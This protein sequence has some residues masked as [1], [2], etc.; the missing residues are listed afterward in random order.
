MTRRADAETA[1]G[2]RRIAPDAP[3]PPTFDPHAVVDADRTRLVLASD[4]DDEV[5]DAVRAVVDAARAGT[6]LDR[7]AVL[8]ASPEPYARLVHEHLAAAGITTN[9]AAVLPLAGRV[10]GRTLLDLLALP[11]RGFR[12]QDVFAWLASAPLLRD[13]R[14]APTPPG[15]GCRVRPASSPAA[16]TGTTAS[17]PSPTERDAVRGRR[18][19]RPGRTRVAARSSPRRK[20][21]AP[22]TSARSC[23]ASSTTSTAPP[24]APAAGA[25]TRA[26]A[27]GRLTELLGGPA[28]RDQ[29]PDSRA[30]GGRAGRAGARP[31][32]RARRGRGGGRARR[33]HPHARARARVRPRAGRPLRRGRARRLRHHGARPRPRPRR[34]ARPGRGLVPRAPSATTRSSPTTS[35][36]PPATSSRCAR[37]GSTASTASSSPRSPARPGTCSASPAATCAAAASASRRA[38]CSTSPAALAGTP[39]APD[40]LLG[41][42]DAVDRARAVVRRRPARLRLPRHR[43]GAPAPQPARRRARARRRPRRGRRPADRRR[44]RGHGR[45]PQRPLHPLRR[46]PR[47]ARH[48]VA[49][50]RAR[51]APRASRRGRAARSPTSSSTC[52]ASS[53]S[54]T[55]RSRCRSSPLDRGSLVHEALERFVLEV[56][57]RP[58]GRAAVAG[59]ALVARRPG[60]ARRDRRRAVRRLRGAGADGPADL[61]APRPGP[62]PRRPPTLP[63][64]RRPG[65]GQRAAP[66]RRRRARR[67]ACATPTL[68]AVP[69]DAARRARRPLPGQGRPGRRRRRRHAPRRRL[70]DR[71]TRNYEG[72]SADDPDPPAPHLQLAVYGAAARRHRATPDAD[73]HAEYWFVSTKGT[74]RAHRLPGHGR[75]PRPGVGASSAPSSTGIEAGVFPSHP[76][77]ASTVDLG[78]VRVVRPRRARHHRAAPRRGTRKRADPRSP[79][80]PTWP[81]RSRVSSPSKSRVRSLD[82]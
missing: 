78:R 39:V 79:A 9:G 27:R 52:S 62:D 24:A 16:P 13:G 38:G 53:G 2:V 5:R 57:D 4:A 8:Y 51:P 12:R 46:Q 58:A 35:A 3:A 32:R 49:G 50:R 42:S 23:S 47:R 65:T 14:W 56:L 48:P 76:T 17:R 41:S 19:R 36:P 67:S 1:A 34:G 63:R 66:A 72:L 21:P 64:P 40:E 25:S 75:R 73:V 22:A 59:R 10:A 45:P 80:T 82:G 44:R 43:A 60:A 7:I 71:S 81:S 6:P 69:L 54:R 29:W 70:Q 55:P 31:P 18:A 30:Q 11:E 26:W 15:S 61:L 68:D 33:L 37:R 74:V 28:R 20:R 77:E